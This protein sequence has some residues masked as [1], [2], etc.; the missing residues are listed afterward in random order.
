MMKSEKM[1]MKARLSQGMPD[2]ALTKSMI[3][4]LKAS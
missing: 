3:A 1:T 2:F 4:S